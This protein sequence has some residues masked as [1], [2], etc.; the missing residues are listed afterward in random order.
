MKFD[1]LISILAAIWFSM[2]ALYIVFARSRL[3]AWKSSVVLLLACAELTLSR[4]MLGISTD[5][6]ARLFWYKI[7]CAGLTIAPAAFLSQ[8]FFYSGISRRLPLFILLG[9]CL[10]PAATIGIVFTNEFHGW[11]WNPAST[12]QIINSMNLPHLTDVGFW[13]WVLTAYNFLMISAG[14]FILIR[15]MARSPGLYFRQAGSMVA[16]AVFVTFGISMDITGISPLPPFTAAIT[17]LAVGGITSVFA[18]IPL[19]RQYI[20]PDAQ[21]AVFNSISDGIIVLDGGNRI[22][23]MNPA[24]EKLLDQSAPHY[25]SK[26]AEHLLPEIKNFLNSSK[27]EDRMMIIEHESTRRTFN[28]RLTAIQDWKK[29][30]ANQVIIMT[31]ITD[32]KRVEAELKAE[33]EAEKNFSEKLTILAAVTNKLSKTHTLD[34]FC[35]RAVEA[36]RDELGFDRL[37]MWFVSEDRSDII[38][39]YGTGADGRTTDERNSHYT[40][41][42]TSRLWPIIQGKAALHRF[43]EAPLYQDG[44]QIGSGMRVAAGLWDGETVIGFLSVDNLINKR[45]FTG[46]D[47]ELLRLYALALGHLCTLKRAQEKLT[48]LTEALELRVEGRT[49]ELQ[50]ANEDLAR[51][52]RAKDEFLAC[53]SHELRTPLTSILG[54]TEMLADQIYGPLNESQ[55]QALLTVNDS[56]QLLMTLINDVLDIAKAEAGKLEL[57]IEPVFVPEVCMAGQRLISVQ[58]GMKKINPAL[59][60]DPAVTILYADERRLKQILVNLLS[61]AV[62]FTSEGGQI[63][64]EVT[65]DTDKNEVY[66]TVWDTGVGISADNQTRLFQPFVQVDNS[67]APTAGS[68]GLGLSIVK[69]MTELH[70]G[71]VSVESKGIPGRGSRFI[72]TL[73]WKTRPQEEIDQGHFHPSPV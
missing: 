19:R 52:L 6:T 21:Y 10:F 66:F 32:S 16:S 53:M 37:S 18:L 64:L 36:G 31:D 25:I 51:V 70:G 7:S 3:P 45:P 54:L 48:N 69:S 47:C 11:V 39:T 55:I 71:R 29:S 14:C 57:K 68:S 59:K 27:V 9:L 26:P 8:A 2:T 17:G 12:A 15:L 4:A 58:A 35:R 65:G 46:H 30:I 44:L 41:V 50:L 60:L 63:G 38:G 72:I 5:Y 49:A 13:Y 20:L 28:L 43:E 33:R 42:Q 34:E 22:V 73:P 67:I 61:N 62:K 40:I 1:I 56:S 23:E 24:A